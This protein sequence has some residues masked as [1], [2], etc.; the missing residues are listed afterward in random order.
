M[1]KRHTLLPKLGLIFSMLTLVAGIVLTAAPWTPELH[2]ALLRMLQEQ[3][4]SVSLL[5]LGLFAIGILLLSAFLSDYRKT[6]VH[7]DMGRLQVSI[8]ETLIQRYVERFWNEEM[9]NY[10]AHCDVRVQDDILSISADLATREEDFPKHSLD[11]IDTK[12]SELLKQTCGYSGRYHLA[13]R[14]EDGDHAH[15]CTES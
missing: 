13:M 14:F 15:P 9:P 8:D 10:P 11:E 2:R 3:P 4:F 7:L 12:L 6:Y 5:G 1:K